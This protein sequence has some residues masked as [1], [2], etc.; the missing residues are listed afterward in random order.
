[1]LKYRMSLTFT[2]QAADKA[3][4]ILKD[5]GLP[6]TSGFRFSI[7]GGGCYG[8]EYSIDVENARKFDMPSKDDKIFISNDIRIIVDKKSLIFMEG[9][10][11]GWEESN[12]GYR[13]TY[14]NPN[15]KG[16]CGCGTSFTT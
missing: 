15:A 2:I 10:E 9:T 6:E 5:K 3:R 7:K 1:M 4:E 8:F 14:S 12:F 11:I 16:I 13:F